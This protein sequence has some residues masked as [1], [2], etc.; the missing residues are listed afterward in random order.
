MYPLVLLQIMRS[1]AGNVLEERYG[2]GNWKTHNLK[3]FSQM[4]RNVLKDYVQ[5]LLFAVFCFVFVV[6]VVAV[7]QNSQATA[8]IGLLGELIN[9]C[10][11]KETSAFKTWSQKC[12]HNVHK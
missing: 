1:V 2:G 3:S 4:R 8:E 10:A 6:V 7:V 5:I 12:L 9:I 11:S